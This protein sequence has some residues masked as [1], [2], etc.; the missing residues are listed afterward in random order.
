VRIHVYATTASSRSSPTPPFR[1]APVDFTPHLAQIRSNNSAVFELTRGLSTVLCLGSRALIS[2]SLGWQGEAVWLRGACTTET[3]G[4][5]LVERLQPHFLYVSDQLEEGC[6]VNLVIQVKRRFPS[7]RTLL[8]VTRPD[9]T[10]RLRAAIQA[11]CDGVMLEARMGL[12]TGVAAIRCV[13]GGGIYIDRTLIEN[14]RTLQADPI[15]TGFEPLSSRETEVLSGI[16]R[17]DTN[18]EI[19]THLQVSLETVKSHSRQVLRKL[20]ARDRTHAA[21]TGLRLGLVD[22]PDP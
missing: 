10:A 6:G 12:G 13:C 1:H 22:W 3:E 4:L 18:Q 15:P 11:G 17:G 7:V 5:A 9:R 14:F 16:V 19:A 8:L 2:M 20:Q 21:V